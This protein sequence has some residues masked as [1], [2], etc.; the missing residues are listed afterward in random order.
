MRYIERLVERIQSF[1]SGLVQPAFEEEACQACGH[2]LQPCKQYALCDLWPSQHCYGHNFGWPFSQ[3]SCTTHCV[4]HAIKGASAGMHADLSDTKC[5]CA[6]LMADIYYGLLSSTVEL[7]DRTMEPFGKQPPKPPFRIVGIDYTD[8]GIEFKCDWGDVGGVVATPGWQILPEDGRTGTSHK[9]S[10]YRQAVPDLAHK[11]QL[12]NA[13]QYGG[14]SN[15]AQLPARLVDTQNWC[16][17]ET[18][19]LCTKCY[20]KA[21]HYSIVSHCWADHHERDIRADLMLGNTPYIIRWRGADARQCAKS[22]KSAAR[23][24][25]TRF[26]WVDSV[27]IDQDSHDDVQTHI[28]NMGNYY[29]NCSGC[30]AILPDSNNDYTTNTSICITTVDK[31]VLLPQP[32][33]DSY[34]F[35]R[36]WTLPELALPKILVLQA[37]EFTIHAEDLFS[38]LSEAELLDGVVHPG[39]VQY[40]RTVS[41]HGR[42]FN[43]LNTM[44]M[45]EPRQA[46]KAQDKVLA[47]RAMLHCDSIVGD[48]ME[49]EDE[50]MKN[51]VQA[52]DERGDK[53]WFFWAGDRANTLPWCCAMPRGNIAYEW[54]TG[55]AKQYERSTALSLLE[56][57]C[58]VTMSYRGVIEASLSSYD[59]TVLGV[60]MIVYQLKELGYE[61]AAQQLGTII[62][63]SC[64]IKV[65]QTLDMA[66]DEYLQPFRL[67]TNA[68]KQDY[69]LLEELLRKGAM[70]F[71][72]GWTV[73]MVRK[74]SEKS[75]LLGNGEFA[76][77][78]LVWSIPNT[79]SKGGSEFCLVGITRGQVVHRRNAG[80]MCSTHK[81]KPARHVVG[82]KNEE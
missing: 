75:L 14:F 76:V 30:L 31:T 59:I 41:R 43:F 3:T 35:G 60:I 7:S 82:M 65:I 10:A 48:Y 66:A 78:D 67:L 45:M 77:G 62:F 50:L 39:L 37:N 6:R 21:M 17:I 23:I 63:G 44:R 58:E 51:L 80:I 22:I 40:M 52:V 34:W 61:D 42:H 54:F 79:A 1:I 29:L 11:C 56:Q 49:H 5:D 8:R 74:D 16:L 46:T 81:A 32:I 27:C 25:G 2:G 57:G 69:L 18:D 38:V 19:Q 53:S 26:V 55:M 64:P 13:S 70:D 9:E 12:C 72:Q 4:M 28:S 20:S 47:M 24:I 33:V 73:G 68:E 36:V 15:M 71:T